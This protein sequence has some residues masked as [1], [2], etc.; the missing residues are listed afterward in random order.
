MDTVPRTVDLAFSSSYKDEERGTVYK[1]CSVTVDRETVDRMYV[2]YTVG[3][4]F[5]TVEI[6]DGKATFKTVS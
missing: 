1:V 2:N 5:G 4:L 3:E 6:V